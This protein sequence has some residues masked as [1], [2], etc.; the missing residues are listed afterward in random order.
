[1]KG[2]IPNLSLQP[3]IVGPKNLTGCRCKFGA[4]IE[5]V[6]FGEIQ[7]MG[8]YFWVDENRQN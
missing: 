7:D 5:N 1:M 2:E 8:R 3:I 6:Y 4:N